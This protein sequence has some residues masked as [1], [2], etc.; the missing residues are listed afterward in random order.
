[1]VKTN[2][3]SIYPMITVANII[4]GNIKNDIPITQKVTIKTIYLLEDQMFR[5]WYRFVSPT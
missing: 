2:G 1:M 5:F 3:Y 4:L